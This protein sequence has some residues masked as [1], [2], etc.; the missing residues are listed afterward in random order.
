MQSLTAAASPGFSPWD[1]ASADTAAETLG[2]PAGL[3]EIAAC[4]ACWVG[5]VRTRAAVH[6]CRLASRNK[7]RSN[8]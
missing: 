8:D 3:A 2:A 6:E 1:L 5:S 4:R 7:L